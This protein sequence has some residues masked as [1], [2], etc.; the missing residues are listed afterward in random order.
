M[1]LRSCG[2]RSASGRAKGRRLLRRVE[3]SGTPVTAIRPGP[4]APRASIIEIEMEL[5]LD[6]SVADNDNEIP[7]EEEEEEEDRRIRSE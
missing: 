5:S 6:N 2:L 1:R 4:K 7:S 3:A